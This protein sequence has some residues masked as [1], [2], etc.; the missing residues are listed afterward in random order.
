MGA[1]NK[2]NWLSC[3]WI[4]NWEK[5]CYYFSLRDSVSSFH[6]GWVAL[7]SV[8]VRPASVTSPLIST[9]WCLWAYK[10]YIFCEDMILATCQCQH[11]FCCWVEPSLLLSSFPRYLL[12][13]IPPHVFFGRTW[14][15]GIILKLHWLASPEGKMLWWPL[16]SYQRGNGWLSLWGKLKM[17]RCSKQAF[18]AHISF[19]H[20]TLWKPYIRLGSLI[21]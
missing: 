20:I 5:N 13:K 16:P 21:R 1:I 15:S 3:W 4:K 11:I 17:E 8:F 12:G 18:F 9:I 14:H 2:R 19:G 7:S 6:C 10:P